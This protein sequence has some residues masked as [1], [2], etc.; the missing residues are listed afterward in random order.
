MV[1]IIYDLEN[2]RFIFGFHSYFKGNIQKIIPLNDLVKEL[3]NK[4][5]R[6]KNRYLKFINTYE[7]CVIST[8]QEGVDMDIFNTV[9]E[10]IK[11]IH[12]VISK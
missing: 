10:K 7:D 6:H 3:G 8:E 1:Q 12:P 5:S 11:V 9:V 4:P 2:A